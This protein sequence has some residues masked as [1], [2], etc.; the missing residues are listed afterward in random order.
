ME[1]HQAVGKLDDLVQ[2]RADQQHRGPGPTKLHQLLTDELRGAHVD[3]TGGL[4]GDDEDGLGGELPGH[5]HLLDVAAG[6]HLHLLLGGFAQDLVFL[7]QPLALGVDGLHVEQG[8]VVELLLVEPI[9]DHVLLDAGGIRDA[10]DHAVLG[11]QGDAHV[12]KLV[13]MEAKGGPSVHDDLAGVGLAEVVEDVHQLPLAVALHAGDAQYLALSHREGY[14]V[15]HLSVPVVGVLQIPHLKHRRRGLGLVLLNGEDNVPA[16]HEAGN[17]LLGGVSGVVDAHG[18]A[19]PQDGHA[20]RDLL[21]LLELVGNEDDG[22]A[23]FLQVDQLP[24]ELHG[25]LGGEHGGGLVQDQDLGAPDQSLQ[26]FHL[27]LHA[28]GDVHDLGV[29]VHFQIKLFA[30]FLGE[31][32]GLREIHEELPLPG[33]HAQDHILRHRQAGHQ[34]EVL[35]DHADPVGN[36]HGG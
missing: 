2:I 32:D 20:V 31:G 18:P 8:P 4:I 25:L 23:L 28:H 13:L 7:H 15:Q 6:E 10:V 35:M 34:H 3:A 5:H 17:L 11:D 19:A 33:F 9:G 30:V 1:D 29:G 16:H 24:E 26:Y 12:P 36:G 22:V 14:L 27:L 21:D